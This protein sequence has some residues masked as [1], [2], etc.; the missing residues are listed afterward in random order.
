VEPFHRLLEAKTRTREGI[1]P[2]EEDEGAVA[3]PV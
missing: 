2:F 1:E 3:V